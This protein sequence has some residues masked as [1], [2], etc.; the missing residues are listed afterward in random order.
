MKIARAALAA[1]LLLGQPAAAAPW[2]QA[3]PAVAHAAVA[4]P[5]HDYFA[6]QA[7]RDGLN[8]QV[9][10]AENG[11]IVYHAAF[12]M[13]DREAGRANTVDTEFELASVAKV[14]TATA[15]L[16]LVERGRIELDAPLRT[17]FPDFPY[18]DIT[19]RQLLSHSSG[20]SD[21][22]IGDYQAAFEAR[23]GRAMTMADVPTAVALADK[24]LKL[25]PGER[26]WY[27]NLGYVLLARL[28][29][30][31]SGQQF[32]SWLQDHILA[33]TGMRQT[34]LRTAL[35]NREGTP[36]VARN[37]DYARRYSPEREAIEGERGYY[38]GVTFGDAN[39]VST[40]TDL[41][42]FDEALRAG[43]LLRPETLEAAYT[44]ARLADG[45]P[46]FVWLNIGGM[47]EADDGLGWFVFRDQTLG[48]VA[49]HAGGMPGSRTILLRDLDHGRTVIVLDNHSSEN[50]YR[51]ALSAMRILAGLPPLATPRSLARQFGRTLVSMGET[52]AVAELETRRADD[53]FSLDEDDMNNLG[54]EFL[55]DGRL[56]EALVTFR[57]NARL[58]PASDNALNSYAEALEAA[59]DMAAA[60]EMYARSLAL[61]PDNTDSRSD[62]ERVEA[63]LD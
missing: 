44:P 4:D 46:V 2:K 48:R 32:Q 14:F 36:L 58:F 49:W 22:D 60:R 52:A 45:T 13:A 8:G 7:A 42:R 28:V 37:Y 51:T 63:A 16:Q 57:E 17:Y 35:I 26:W 43:L 56:P 34:Y 3:G 53:G 15:V 29:E 54:Y 25:R 18:P 30:E 10:V 20:L 5:L 27:C 62:L 12:G 61:N 59:G 38:N 19:I 9:L 33:P 23:T 1:T 55:V 31:R 40:A 39:I 41:L 24:P 47:G 11:R 50:G 21:Q 6:A